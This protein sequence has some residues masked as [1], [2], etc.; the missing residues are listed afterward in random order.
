MIFADHIALFECFVNIAPL[1]MAGDIDVQ[2]YT[3]MNLRRIFFD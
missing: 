3:L 1:D 2:F